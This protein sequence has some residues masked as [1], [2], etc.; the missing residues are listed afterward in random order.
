M[1]DRNNLVFKVKDILKNYDLLVSTV[2]WVKNNKNDILKLTLEKEIKELDFYKITSL[3]STQSRSPLWQKYFQLNNN[4]QSVG[5]NENRGDLK[6]DGKYYEYKISLNDQ[7][8]FRL[9][10]I[11]IWQDCDYIFQF[12]TFEKVYT[13]RLSKKDME[14]ELKLCRASTA[15]GTIKSNLNNQNVEKAITIRK[16]SEHWKRWINKYRLE[17]IT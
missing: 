10:Q 15:H 1:K 14:Y 6:K 13:F 8:N 2:D 7:V 3:L 5:K 4:F 11:R 17:T 12:L 16:G 9:I